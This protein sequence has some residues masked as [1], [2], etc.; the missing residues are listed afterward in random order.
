MIGMPKRHFPP[1][2]S[3][4]D[5]GACFIVRDRAGQAL[6][7]VDYE[8]EPGRRTAAGLL[9]WDEARRIATNIAK[10]PKRMKRSEVA[11]ESDPRPPFRYLDYAEQY[12]KAL[13]HLPAERPGTPPSWPRYLLL[14]HSIELALKAYLAL[15]GTALDALRKI[16]RRHKLDRLVNEAVEKGLALP[17]Q[18]QEIL[19]LLTKAHSKLLH[20]YPPDDGLIKDVYLIHQFVAAARELLNAASDEIRGPGLGVADAEIAP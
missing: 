14:C 9:T 20:R 3:V 12:F 11:E 4:E 18:T 8:E 6:A 5:N 1:P 15:R 16:E 2:W 17:T 7:Y 19:K 10:I 13:E